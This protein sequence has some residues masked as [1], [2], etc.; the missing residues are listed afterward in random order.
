MAYENKKIIIFDLDG[1]LSLSKS[2]MDD[3]MLE[4]VSKLLE[5]KK[6]AVISGASFRQFQK[7]F[8][9]ALHPSEKVLENLYLFPTCGACFYRYQEGQWRIIYTETFSAEEKKKIMDAFSKAFYNIGF[10]RGSLLCMCY[11]FLN[12]LSRNNTP[13]SIT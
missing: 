4:L 13:P 9:Q 1:T 12:S 8:L 11:F 2:P 10:C 7:Q 5:K 3:E 6:A